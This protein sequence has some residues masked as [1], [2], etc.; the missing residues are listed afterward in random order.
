MGAH[1]RVLKA[2]FVEVFLL[3]LLVGIWLTM[4]ADETVSMQTGN[5][6]PNE[7]KAGDV[8]KWVDFGVSYEAM[9][10]AYQWDVDTYGEAVHVDWVVLLAYAGAKNGGK[11]GRGALRD[12]D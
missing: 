11:F 9:N 10:K 7:Y 3:A 4:S 8:I 5:N 1:R 6:M 12:I 2:I